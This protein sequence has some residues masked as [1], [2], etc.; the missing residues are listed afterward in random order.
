M[1]TIFGEQ[2]YNVSSSSSTVTIPSLLGSYENGN[3]SNT[4]R[5]MAIAYKTVSLNMIA[6]HLTEIGV[7]N[8]STPSAL[9]AV[10]DGWSIPITITLHFF[11]LV[12]PSGK[13]VGGTPFH[14]PILP[15][16][17]DSKG[18]LCAC[19]EIDETKVG[20]KVDPENKFVAVSV[21]TPAPFGGGISGWTPRG[22]SISVTLHS[23]SKDEDAISF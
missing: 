12:D 8:T 22:R 16:S 6:V 5:S 1:E 2:V 21:S 14:V 17:L 10:N 4:P 7:D 9:K 18:G 23:Q 13:P 20:C 3:S 15:G 19:Y 11:C